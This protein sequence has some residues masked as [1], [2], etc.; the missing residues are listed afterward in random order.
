VSRHAL[1][2][3]PLSVVPTPLPEVDA[4]PA[5]ATID[6]RSLSLGVLAVLASLFMLRWASPVIVPVM[7]ALTLAYALRSTVDRLACW[8]VP[9]AL[10]AA[11]VLA[12]LVAAL[13]FAVERLRNDATALAESLPEAAQK[14]RQAVR[15]ER[16]SPDTALDKVQQ[17]AVQLQK[18]TQEGGPPPPPPERGVTRVQIEPNHFDL[19]AYVWSNT[20]RLLSGLGETTVVVLMAYFLLAGGDSF[21]RK[22]VKIAGPSL[23]RRKITVQGLN[24]INQQIQRYL[25][26]QVAI[27]VFVGVATWGVYSAIGLRHAAVWG[28]AAFALNFVPYLGSI[29]LTVASGFVAFVQFGSLDMALLVGAAAATLHMITGFVL[30]PWLT[31]RTS[32]LSALAVFV[33]VLAFG[34]L[35]GL[36]GLMLGVPMLMMVKAVCDRVEGL[37]PIG[38]LLGR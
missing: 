8:R 19:K 6:G 14:V 28:A 15:K 1:T 25:L 9:R 11:L 4:E 37:E 36:W 27:S 20:P 7:L 34:W 31:S 3:K 23:A 38:E 29:V 16:S 35:W 10:G 17:A 22:L 13:A 24:E 2:T 5:A 30:T 21:R 32:R 26:V 12:A 18:A 33:S